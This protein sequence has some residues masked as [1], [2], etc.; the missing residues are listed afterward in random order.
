MIRRSSTAHASNTSALLRYPGARG[1]VVDLARDRRQR[2]AV[3]VLVGLMVE[4]ERDVGL[5]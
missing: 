4:A 3:L 2:L 1:E 5:R